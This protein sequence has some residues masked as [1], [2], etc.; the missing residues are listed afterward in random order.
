[1]KSLV[2]I[3]LTA[4]VVYGQAIEPARATRKNSIH[5]GTGVLHARQIDNGYTGSSLL[6]RGTNLALRF[7]YAHEGARQFFDVSSSFSIGKLKSKSGELPSDFYYVEVSA[8][9]LR[10]VATHQLFGKENQFFAGLRLGTINQGLANI[11]QIDN[12]G[13]Y[14]LHGAYIALKNRL[15]LDDK[16]SLQFSWFAP[17]V[18]Y[19]NRLL[20]NGG[21]T[22]ITTRN[23]R[24]IPA[25]LTTQGELSYFSIFRNVQVNLTY[26]TLLSD[27]ADASIRYRFFYA[28]SSIKDAYH[29]YSNELIAS[30]HFRF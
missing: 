15:K 27:K 10:K 9:Y 1:M 16:R 3:I 28:S 17:T 25:L 21:A 18:V 26:V 13:V 22:D 14:S 24:N 23:F 2:I 8:D 20:Y 4:S 11:F 12:I 7:G 6:F 29:T 5:V 30:L 19:E